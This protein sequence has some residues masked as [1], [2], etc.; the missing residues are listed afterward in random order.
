[1]RAAESG[2]LEILGVPA[3]ALGAGAGGEMRHGRPR[4]GLRHGHD[5][6]FQIVSLPLGGGVPP[7]SLRESLLTVKE[8]CAFHR[9]LIGLRRSRRLHR[10]QFS[11][12]YNE[13]LGLA[14]ALE[15]QNALTVDKNDV[16]AAEL[17]D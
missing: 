13:S 14:P 15:P 7:R 6:S 5:L 1:M 16:L 17:A 8:L 12:L 10:E 2:I 4:S 9:R 3:R 11:G